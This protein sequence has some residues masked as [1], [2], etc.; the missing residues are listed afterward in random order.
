MGYTKL[1]AGI[2][3]IF[4]AFSLQGCGKAMDK[5]YEVTCTSAIDA[6]VPEM[7]KKAEKFADEKCGNNTGCINATK[8]IVNMTA[9]N[10][11]GTLTAECVAAIKAAKGNPQAVV[12]FLTNSSAAKAFNAALEAA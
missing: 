2:A 12:T 7:E 8:N 3:L 10:A 6:M 4:V 9:M 5:I 11:N 1:A